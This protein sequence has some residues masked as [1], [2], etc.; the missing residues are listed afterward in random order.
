MDIPGYY[1]GAAWGCGVELLSV[2]RRRLI[3]A[4]RE[5][6]KGRS[7]D[8]AVVDQFWLSGKR[9]GGLGSP[10]GLFLD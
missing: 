2:L 6:G 7:G 5:A 10:P 1:L 3:C 9:P 4:R 8:P